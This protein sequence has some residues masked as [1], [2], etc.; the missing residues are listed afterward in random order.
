MPDYASYRQKGR[1]LTMEEIIN[2]PGDMLTMTQISR[3]MGTHPSR[4]CYYAD[5]KQLPFDTFRSGNRYKVPKLVF[6]QFMG[7]GK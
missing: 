7:V 2:Y 1:G 4:L 5:T 3:V 6:L